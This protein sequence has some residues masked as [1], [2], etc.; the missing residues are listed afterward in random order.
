MGVYFHIRCYCGIPA[1]TRDSS[2]PLEACR[3]VRLLEPREPGTPHLALATG[4]VPLA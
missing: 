2:P 4:I 3:R 1:A